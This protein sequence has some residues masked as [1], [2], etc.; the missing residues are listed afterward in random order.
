MPSLVP[1]IDHCIYFVLCDYGP[2]VGRAFVETD[3]DEADRETIIHAIADAQ[4]SKVA[5]VLAVDPAA[6]MVTDV[7][8]DILAEVKERVFEA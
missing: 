2:G 1:K 6:G 8:A 3:P 5:Q 4:Y 7:T